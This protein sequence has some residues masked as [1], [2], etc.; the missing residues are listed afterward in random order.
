MVSLKQLILKKKRERERN[1]H[2]TRSDYI[3]KI[4]LKYIEKKVL[5]TNDDNITTKMPKASKVV[6]TPLMTMTWTSVY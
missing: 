1:T 3:R 5:V 2:I 4:V 6:G